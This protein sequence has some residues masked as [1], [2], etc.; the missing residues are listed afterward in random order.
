MYLSSAE[1][2]NRRGRTLGRLEDKVK[3]HM[4]ERGVRGK[5]LEWARRECMNRER[6]RAICCGHP[7]RG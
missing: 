5:G 2:P 6:W 1:G 4:S 7:L 3:E